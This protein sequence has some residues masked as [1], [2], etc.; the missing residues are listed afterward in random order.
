MVEPTSPLKILYGR[1]CF[2]KKGQHGH[3]QQKDLPDRRKGYLDPTS[4]NS[5]QYVG[6]VYRIS[7]TKDGITIFAELNNGRD[8]KI[9]HFDIYH[10]TDGVKATNE[11]LLE[12]KDGEMMVTKLSKSNPSMASFLG[13]MITESLGG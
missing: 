6:S 11:Y 7:Q 1:K 10:I 9:E 5:E 13:R 3:G 2:T 12:D 8:V 4:M